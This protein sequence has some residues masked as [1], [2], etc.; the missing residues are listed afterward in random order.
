MASIL[1]ILNDAPYGN[2]RAY[3]ALRPAAEVVRWLDSADTVDG[4]AEA[5]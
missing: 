2:E 4:W 1:F 5:A 3:S